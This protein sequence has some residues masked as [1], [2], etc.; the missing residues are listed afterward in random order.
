[1][2]NLEGFVATFLCNFITTPLIKRQ[3]IQIAGNKQN[4]FAF[5]ALQFR[6]NKCYRPE[7]PTITFQWLNSRINEMLFKSQI[8]LKLLK[9]AHMH[10]VCIYLKLKM[11]HWYSF[12]G[13][14]NGNKHEF[15]WIN[16]LLPLSLFTM[17]QEAWPDLVRLGC[18]REKG[19]SNLCSQAELTFWRPFNFNNRIPVGFKSWLFAKFCL[20]FLLDL[21]TCS[22]TILVSCR[23]LLFLWIVMNNSPEVSYLHALV[24]TT[25]NFID[26]VLPIPTTPLAKICFRGSLTKQLCRLRLFLKTNIE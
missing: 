22:T 25:W 19:Q 17:S 6:A 7:L 18:S 21:S 10:Y 23:S 14:I 3:R 9:T 15:L 2:P 24:E 11:A 20:E 13:I 1:M 16:S 4:N 8:Y 12:N 5:N 26:K